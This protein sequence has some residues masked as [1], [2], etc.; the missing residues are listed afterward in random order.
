M[1]RSGARARERRADGC[2]RR[3]SHLRVPGLQRAVPVHA[4]ELGWSGHPGHHDRR[5]S[6]SAAPDF[7]I[8]TVDK[9]AQLPWNGRLHTLF[10]R[11][12]ERCERHGYRSRDLLRVGRKQEANYHN[13]S[14]GLPKASTVACDRLR[15]PDLIIQDELHLISGPLGTL[16]G[17]YEA[18]IDRLAK[19]LDRR[20][21]HITEGHRLDGDD[22]SRPR[23]RSPKSSRA[24]SPCFRRRASTLLRTSSPSNGTRRRRRGDAMSGSARVVSA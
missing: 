7:L 10:G 23:V 17:L 13:A 16:V 18:A 21:S 12:Y 14:D 24:I 11:V 19:R 8:A 20:E 15:P 1:V 22:P 4:A 3:S 6:V 9:L 2:R 5:G